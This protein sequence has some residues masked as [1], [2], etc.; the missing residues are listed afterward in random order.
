MFLISLY[1][2]LIVLSILNVLCIVFSLGMRRF[3]MGCLVMLSLKICSRFRLG[4]RVSRILAFGVIL[5]PLFVLKIQLIFANVAQQSNSTTPNNNPSYTPS[6]PSLTTSPTSARH[7]TQ[8][9]LH[10]VIKSH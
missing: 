9:T 3:S 7:P 6:S 5:Q 4:C 10:F 2:Q 8:T 1:L